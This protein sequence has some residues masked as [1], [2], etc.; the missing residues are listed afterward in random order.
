ML[1]PL[2][3]PEK[4]DAHQRINNHIIDSDIK[5]AKSVLAVLIAFCMVLFFTALL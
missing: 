2:I 1:R 3:S 5:A 4:T